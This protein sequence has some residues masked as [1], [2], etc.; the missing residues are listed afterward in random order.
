LNPVSESA[1]KPVS[2]LHRLVE[3]AR[4]GPLQAVNWRYEHQSVLAQ[5]QDGIPAP[6]RVT[7]HGDLPPSVESNPL[8]QRRRKHMIVSQV[9]VKAYPKLAL[10]ICDNIP[11]VRKKTKIFRAFQK[12]AKLSEEVAERAIKHGSPPVIEF[13]HLPTENGIFWGSKYPDTVFISKDICDRFQRYDD[14]AN[15]PRM[16]VLVESTLLHEIVH[17]GVWLDGAP[18]V[19]EDGRAFEKEAYG[20]NIRQYWGPPSP[21]DAP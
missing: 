12:Y 17:W 16:H 15:D 1:E 5:A 11:K 19:Q 18:I 3:L 20:K 9:L 8:N 21:D 7:D 2:R 13:R 14:D 4:L 10:W 6:S